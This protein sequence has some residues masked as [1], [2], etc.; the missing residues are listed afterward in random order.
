MKKKVV[1]IMLSMAMAATLLAGCGSTA[2]PAA[3]S[4][5]PAASEAPAASSAAPASEVSSA[6]EAASEISSAAS[7]GD[8]ITVGFAQVGHESDWRAASTTSAQTVFSKENGFDLQFNDADN[9]SAAQ[10]EA[11]RGFIEQGVDYIVIDPIVATGWDTV[12]TEASDAGIPVFVI[13]RTI[14]DSTNYTAWY[15][16]DFKSEGEAA[17]AWL[18]EYLK[19]KNV[20]G[21]VNIAVISGTLGS[22]AQIGRSDGF[23]EYVSKNSNW[24]KIDEQSGDFT[25]D[26]GQEIMESFLKSYKDIDVV[27]CQNDNEAFGA[28]DALKAAGKTYG[29]DGD[30]III[31]FDSTNA[32]LTS[33]LAGDINADFECNPLSAPYVADGIKTLQGGGKI[34]EQQVYIDEACFAADDTVKSVTVGDKTKDITVVTQD[35]IDS[36]AY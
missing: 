17:G 13:D 34:T 35:V 20:T 5:A 16:S 27:V 12:L 8:L 26:G 11:I 19:A 2:A 6:A 22:S 23:D 7:S 4:A 10:L 36:R 9:D 31:S 25:Q 33:V 21:D 32:G 18:Q 1:S 28:I 30:T 3:S 15:G 29:K 14:D 24:K